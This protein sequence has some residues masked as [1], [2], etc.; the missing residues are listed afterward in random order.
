M[1]SVLN[2]LMIISK[3]VEVADMSE[4][5]KAA[6]VPSKEHKSDSEL[7][8]ELIEG[9]KKAGYKTTNDRKDLSVC[10]KVMF[11]DIREMLSDFKAIKGIVGD[12][13]E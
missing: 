1:A 5:Q 8:D 10:M 6:E 7:V 4:L 13:H 11:M 12:Y 9:M 3:L 2:L